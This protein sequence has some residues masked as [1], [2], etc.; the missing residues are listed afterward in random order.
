[1]SEVSSELSAP[2]SRRQKRQQAVAAARRIAWRFPIARAAAGVIVVIALGIVARVLLV[3][4]PDGGRPVASVEISN[5]KPANSVA[6]A[7]SG[8]DLAT[9]TADPES[10]P[11][12]DASPA[13]D[14]PAGAGLASINPDLVETTAVGPIPKISASGET[15]FATYSRPLDDAAADTGKP[16]IAIIVSG[17]GINQDGTLNAIT[18]LPDAVTLAFAPYGKTLVRTVAA[19][20]DGGHEIF[21]EVPLEPFDYPDND[22]G[23]DTLLTGQAPRDNLNKLFHVMSR[24]EGYA[25]LI[26]NMGAR[27]TSSGADFGPMMEELGSRGLGYVDDGSSN[28]SLAP[29]LADANRVPFGKVDQT[30]DANPSRGAILTQL[31]KLMDTARSNGSAIG[32]IS[33][34]PVSIDT[35]AE[36]ASSPDAEGV[37]LVPASALMKEA[38]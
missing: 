34:L 5:A 10:T 19:A 13:A 28:R 1:M 2:L 23:P 17:L 11:V 6:G 27:F 37:E 12:P 24:F 3:H 15:P 36:W 26:N 21:L 8:G 22:P 38:S 30:L 29:Q 35:I 25:G 32:I 4:D 33:A 18:K 31:K 7:V 20:R 14:E 16:R 9:I